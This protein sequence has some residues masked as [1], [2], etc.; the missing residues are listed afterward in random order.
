MGRHAGLFALGLCISGIGFS[1]IG[2]AQTVILYEN[3]FEK[4]NVPLMVDCGNSL[5][6]RGIN[7]LYGEKDFEFAQDFTVE[8]VFLHDPSGKYKN[9]GDHG[10][11]ALGMLSSV[12]DDKLAL[13]FDSRGYSFINVGLDLSSIDVEGCAGPFGVSAPKLRITLLDRPDGVV[14]YA[15]TE[16]ATQDVIGVAA[17]DAWTF[18]WK[19]EAVGLS[20]E[21]TKDGKVTIVFDLLEGGYAVFD[22]LNITASMSSRVV[23]LDLDQVAD[24]IDN[25][26]HV[27]NTD[28]KDTDR[29]GAGDVCDPA[30]DDRSECGDRDRN[31]RDDCSG[32]VVEIPDAGIDLPAPPPRRDAGVVGQDAS[33]A[34]AST[35]SAG[36]G[37]EAGRGG[38]GGRGGSS[39]ATPG[40]TEESSGC[41]CSVP[42][43]PSS[44]S[45]GALLLLG[46]AALWI[47]RMR[48]R[49]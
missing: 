49:R 12:Q 14:D 35:P 34:D 30:V 45:S 29:D 37:A 26:P 28:Q 48:P 1:P 4:P 32:A 18:R 25:C 38:S 21:G 3:N 20:T 7:F 13:A 46:A 36:S 17:A 10:D 5:D 44:P 23:D 2:H 11:Y 43:A 41:G 8:A 31:G 42:G 24:D 39:A 6:T 47:T 16:L 19:R 22:N 15:Q 9:A 27:A 40:K 33:T